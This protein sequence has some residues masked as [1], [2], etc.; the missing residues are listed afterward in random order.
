MLCVMLCM[1]SYLYL[2]WSCNVIKTNTNQNVHI[3][4]STQ[5]HS[6]VHQK[7]HK[8]NK[9]L[10]CV[11]CQFIMWQYLNVYSLKYCTCSLS[12][13][14]SNECQLLGFNFKITWHLY[15]WNML[16]YM[17]LFLSHTVYSH[18]LF[19][20]FTYK[21]TKKLNGITC[22]KEIWELFMLL[23]SSQSSLK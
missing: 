18:G 6:K 17:Q 11:R 15:W 1:Y 22:N 14:K 5:T 9:C 2:F 7:L 12:I 3:F 23:F 21:L 20:W 8:I 4:L 16:F 19:T 13:L 10:A